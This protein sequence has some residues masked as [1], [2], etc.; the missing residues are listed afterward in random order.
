M[1]KYHKVFLLIILVTLSNIANSQ[2]Q[3]N[4]ENHKQLKKNKNYNPFKDPALK[5][6]NSQKFNE[7]DPLFSDNTHQASK[8]EFIAWKTKVS[9]ENSRELTKNITLAT[10][11]LIPLLYLIYSIVVFFMKLKRNFKEN[12][13]FDSSINK[14]GFFR[15]ANPIKN[16]YIIWLFFNFIALLMSFNEDGNKSK[17]WPFLDYDFSD[18]FSDLTKYY[19]MSEFMFYTLS[20]L[21]VVYF[22][23]SYFQKKN[24][25]KKN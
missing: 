13:N 20:P 1:K 15:V 2:V 10:L 16:A 8:E 19:D 18:K 12:N 3:K 5:H 11:I 9:E 25:Q 6:S 4:D 22:I 14:G 24:S 7:I 23:Y 17:F 21:L